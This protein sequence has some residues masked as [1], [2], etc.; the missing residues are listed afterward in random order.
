MSK[1]SGEARARY[2]RDMFAQ[3]AQHYDRMNR[4]MTAGQDARWRRQVIRLARLQPQEY[5]LDL[6]AGT[7]ELAREAVNQQPAAKV[8]AVDFTLQML[9]AA[10]GRAP[11]NRCAADALQLP[12]QD[13]T[14]DAVV[15]GFLMRNVVD[16]DQ[17][18]YE[19]CRVL[20]PKGRLVILDTT[21]PQPNL[22]W[23]PA[24]IHMH[25]VIPTLGRLVA[26]SRDPYV[27]LV[28]S[29]DSF[30][31]AGELASRMYK[32]GLRTIQFQVLM[33]G[34]IAIHWGERTC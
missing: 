8:A 22:F 32:A 4:L 12:F 30:L 20:K 9:A 7:G 6:G 11:L 27:Y 10:Q 25:I 15:S 13:E 1:L 17:A 2:V 31:S 5:L 26:G 28:E 29:T 18:L 14:F 16:V 3:I 19:Q 21:R 33:F 34:T 24:W 23:P